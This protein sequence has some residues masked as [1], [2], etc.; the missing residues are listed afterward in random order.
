MGKCCQDRDDDESR[1]QRA[2][3]NAAT[4][5]GILATRQAQEHRRVRDRIHDREKSHEDRQGLADSE[6]I[7]YGTA[8]HEWPPILAVMNA[9]EAAWLRA[10]EFG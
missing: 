8:R 5:R 9:R 4:Q 6:G 1:Q 10:P 2:E 3:G 7:G